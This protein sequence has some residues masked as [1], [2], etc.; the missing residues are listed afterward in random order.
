MSRIKF[1]E[2]CLCA[3]TQVRL[4]ARGAIKGFWPVGESDRRDSVYR[5]G[6]GFG[7]AVLCAPHL[8]LVFPPHLQY[9]PHQSLGPLRNALT[10]FPS[11][12]KLC[13]PHRAIGPGGWCEEVGLFEV[14]I[15]DR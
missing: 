11:T 2:K 6:M 4:W 10:D 9:T 12:R 3:F 1:C 15:G 13:P 8:V 7:S 14:T 5:F